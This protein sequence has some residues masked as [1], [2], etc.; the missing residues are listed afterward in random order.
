MWMPLTSRPEAVEDYDLEHLTGDLVGLLD[1]LGI[2]KA[3]FVG[4]DWGGFVVWHMPLRHPHRVAG[5]VGVNTPHT[6]RAPVDP[7]LIYRK[8]FGD[9]MYIVQFQDPA[10]EP[11]RI[12]GS[13]V[14]QT[15]DAFMRKP[16]PRKEIER[17]CRMADAH[18][19][20]TRQAQ[21]YDTLVGERGTTLSGGQRQR[22]AIARALL[23]HLHA[24][25]A[26]RDKRLVTLHAHRPDGQAFLTA[27]GAEEKHRSVENRMDIAAVDWREMLA[28]Q[29]ATLPP[30][31]AWEIHEPRV[32]AT[33][34][35]TL[36]DQF[37]ALL[38]SMPLG[39][40]D[41][42]PI[43]YELAATRAWYEELD[44]HGGAHY[45]V[46]LMA[47]PQV[48]AMCEAS[49]DARFPDRLFQALTAVAPGWQGRG[50]AKA[51]K[52]AML[53]L[54]HAR[55]PQARWMI[56]SNAN[57]NAPMLSINTRLGFAVHRQDVSYQLTQAALGAYL[58]G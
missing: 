22:L 39:A 53:R 24:V 58:D 52:A 45:L 51:V 19:F 12:F 33:R 14:E 55:H 18:D 29:S 38:Q 47:G 13:R 27:I 30:G 15:F 31:L 25:M 17:A 49:F 3:I 42:P 10:R 2:D 23:R 44:R 41:I 32:P 1:H 35:A 50:L 37:T 34:L 4:H 7:L 46:L 20:I 21:G 26:A 40:L 6:P 43:R 57:V 54:V 8:R 28:W 5:V 48:A 36:L 16:M 56:T 9:T 11:D